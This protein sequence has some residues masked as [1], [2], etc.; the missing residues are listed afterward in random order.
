[1]SKTAKRLFGTESSVHCSPGHRSLGSADGP[2]DGLPSQP[3][4]LSR[5]GDSIQHK[6][7]QSCLNKSEDILHPNL[8]ASNLTDVNI[9]SLTISEASG[10]VIE[11]LFESS[12][13]VYSY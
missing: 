8:Y 1:M 5:T 4:L 12:L 11:A 3:S 6:A 2:A 9:F 13:I 10:R 7:V